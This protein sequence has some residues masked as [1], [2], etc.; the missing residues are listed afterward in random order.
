MIQYI[1]SKNQ[2]LLY[3]GRD[4]SGDQGWT[5]VLL[6]KG[7]TPVSSP[8]S[9][10]DAFS[11]E[12]LNASFLFSA[13][14]LTSSETTEAQ[15]VSNV[16]DLPGQQRAM[17]WFV[18][19]D[20][21]DEN[22][23]FS[24]PFS[25]TG[26]SSDLTGQTQSLLERALVDQHLNFRVSSEVDFTLDPDH[27][28]I[29][30]KRNNPP[31]VVF[32]GANAP[33]IPG[34]ITTAQL[35]LQGTSRG[36][37]LF[38]ADISRSD[39]YDE[40]NWGF[41][42][43]IP[44]SYPP[45]QYSVGWYPLAL[46]DK[47][48]STDYIGFN[49]SID[50][51]DRYNANLAGR[52]A[53]YF[54]GNT[55]YK[56]GVT[57]VSYYQT[58]F[59]QTL[60]LNPLTSSTVSDG[61]K[62][63]YFEI[64]NSVTTSD[65]NYAFHFSPVGDFEISING[66]GAEDVF[67]L[68]CGLEGT[69]GISFKSQSGQQKGDRLRFVPQQAAYIPEFPLKAVSPVGRPGSAT[70]SL[71]NSTFLTSYATLVPAEGNDSMPRYFAQPKGSSLYG[72]QSTL[73][74]QYS[75]LL[76][77]MQAGMPLPQ[78]NGFCFPLF[79]Y[80][81]LFNPS[82]K[83]S[84]NDTNLNTFSS[85]NFKNVEETILAPS[86]KMLIR[87]GR[88]NQNGGESSSSK[89]ADT[90]QPSST[91]SG[92]LVELDPSSGQY[93]NIKLGYNELPARL[94]NPKISQLYMH[95]ADPETILQ[96]A[97]QTNQLFLVIANGST[98]LIGELVDFEQQSKG[99][100][101]PAGKPAFYNAMNVGEWVMEANVGDNPA[102]GEYTNVVIVKGRR[103]TLKD[104]VQ[105]TQIWTDPNNFSAPNFSNKAMRASQK[106]NG[107]SAASDSNGSTNDQIPVLSQWILDYIADA[108]Q[109]KSSY[110]QYFNDTIVNDPNWTGILVLKAH[111]EN[112]PYDL[113]G[114]TAGIDRSMFFAHHF[115]IQLSILDGKS[116][117][118]SQP[119]SVF[120]LIYYI[121]PNY[122]PQSGEQPISPPLGKIYDFKVLTLKVL[123]RN[124]AVEDF[125]SLAQLTINQLFDASVKGMGD[126]GNPF[127]AMLLKGTYQNTGGV[128]T[129]SMSNIYVGNYLC[130][131]NI[132]PR[133][134]IDSAVMSTRT[135]NE[136]GESESVFSLTGFL[137]FAIL[138]ETLINQ[139]TKKSSVVDF[140]IFSFGNE[141]GK[142]VERQGLS[143]SNL[144]I[145]MDYNSEGQSA[146]TELIFDSSA[147]T[148]DLSAST[149]RQDCLYKAFSLKPP[150]L[151]HGTG[152]QPGDKGFDRVIVPYSQL[153]GVSNDSWYGLEFELNL[154]TLGDLAGKV[155][156]TSHLL[157][158]WSPNSKS[159]SKQYTAEFGL[160]LPGSGSGGKL[161]SFETVLKLS[162]GQ[163][164]FAYVDPTK[165][166]GSGDENRAGYMLTLSNIALKFL[167]IL[168]LPPNGATSFYLFG[169][170]Q[171]ASSDSGMGWLAYYKQDQ[172]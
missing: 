16:H 14:S 153:T 28:V 86:R 59:G 140:D 115:G 52:T 1:Q 81:G 47:P 100:T 87:Q 22:S 128:A 62:P 60:N 123:F 124:S 168:K 129:Y 70:A 159:T 97:F 75:E 48:N 102:Y 169:S 55:N 136:T 134:E 106:K 150:S 152:V 144:L 66:A 32:S 83:N 19:P 61:E 107:T 84:G 125:D 6:G 80:K 63:A 110:F 24:L 167:G 163:I 171:D 109:Q 122:D 135:T 51:S 101:P 162:I 141:E 74:E 37:F 25:L 104:L 42:A 9:L 49:V 39:L 44:N 18:D 147:V 38:K 78:G 21:V 53:F 56:P 111:I 112:I 91:P 117:S 164:M 89:A 131:S 98:N 8:L 23:A 96:E 132:L 54:D 5:A 79:P 11:N 114:L 120:G 4:Q 64:S 82:N 165:T 27:A 85:D 133:I 143:F 148:F 157:L 166:G 41:Q 15:L 119:S 12:K 118:W 17:V 116:M 145:V 35:P 138:K 127:N 113:A 155:G 156:L 126:K 40:L 73:H 30:F 72:Q 158:A 10:Q 68:L 121:D 108:E 142:T 139:E 170:K 34:N 95:F 43:L 103:G 99:N 57:L 94:Q 77:H 130:D 88:A 50:P 137:D 92:V 76:G 58:R 69:E 93:T 146:D 31:A 20:K 3:I 105:N 29:T 161:I 71:L 67:Q 151:V 149:P 154:G 13:K 26:K 33:N 7:V 172:Q 2:P 160:M 46:E 65:N 90:A 45:P 36:C